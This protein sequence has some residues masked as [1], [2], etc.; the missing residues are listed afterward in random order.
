[1]KI[2]R[3]KLFKLLKRNIKTSITLGFILYTF[4]HYFTQYSHE[5]V[6]GW[7]S[8]ISRNINLYINPENN[9]LILSP[10]F[11]CISSYLLIIVHSAVAN[12]KARTAVRNTWANK[13]NIYFKYFKSVNKTIEVAFILGKS[14]NKTLNNKILD[15]NSRYGDIIQEDFIDTY[16]NLTI[17]S[18][19]MLK[20][21]IAKCPRATFI[22]KTDDDIY[23]NIPV[24]MRALRTSNT[25]R[26]LMGHILIDPL[27]ITDPGNKW[28]VPDYMFWERTYPNFTA[29]SGYI[30]SSDVGLILYKTALTTPLIHMEDVYLTGICAQKA[31]L[32]HTT[33]PNFEYWHPPFLLKFLYT[34]PRNYI[35]VHCENIFEMYKIWN[36]LNT[37]LHSPREEK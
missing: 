16:N 8:N 13:Q 24:L 15:E 33:Y 32:S 14:K 26:L 31:N 1:M 30:M 25:T 23:I 29:G 20:W 19:M 34:E 4:V 11:P 18:M 6:P 9:T 17:K 36:E 35:T 2:I 3:F 21:A 10:K 7:E 22:M 27:R 5:Q 28:Y 12:A 37:V